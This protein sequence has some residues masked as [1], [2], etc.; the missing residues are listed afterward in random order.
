MVE[1]HFPDLSKH[2]DMPDLFQ[3][4]IA[5]SKMQELEESISEGTFLKKLELER[6]LQRQQFQFCNEQA[7]LVRK[8]ARDRLRRKTILEPLPYSFSKHLGAKAGVSTNSRTQTEVI[9]TAESDTQ[10]ARVVVLTPQQFKTVKETGI[11]PLSQ[12]VAAPPEQSLLDPLSE[13]V[14]EVQS[15]GRLMLLTN[16]EISRKKKCQIQSYR[17]LEFHS[18]ANKG[19]H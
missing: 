10:T 8:E 5:V 18:T 17:E 19:K 6:Q 1:L 16:R 15:L 13:P 4:P 7:K 9:I 14:F 2:P 12:D 11:V 3:H